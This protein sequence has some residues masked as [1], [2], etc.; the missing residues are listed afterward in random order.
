[1]EKIYGLSILTKEQ[2]S[3]FEKNG[4][5]I[6]KDVLSNGEIKELLAVVDRI[7]KKY[8]S[9]GSSYLHMFDFFNKNQIFLELIDN[10]K[11]LPLVLGLLGWNIYMFHAHLDI[12]RPINRDGAPNLTWHRDNSRM[13]RD[14]KNGRYPLVA[15]KVAYWLSDVSEEDRGNLYV[16]PGSHNWDYNQGQ[17]IE[18]HVLPNNAVPILVKPGTVL[19]FDSRIWHTRSNNFSQV[20]RKVLFLGYS[21]RWLR[22]RDNAKISSHLLKNASPIQRQLLIRDIDSSAYVPNDEDVPLKE[23]HSKL[24]PDVSLSMEGDF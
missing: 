6:I 22:P 2:E 10:N 20:T 11:I 16:I 7:W 15:L 12:N 5:L 23:L 18:N 8:C 19:L 4:F 3:S 24:Y 13:N 17:A 21:Y 9:E 1:M 14:F